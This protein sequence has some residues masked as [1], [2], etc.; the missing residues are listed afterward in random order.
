MFYPKLTGVKNR[1]N[2]INGFSGLSHILS[3]DEHAFYDMENLTGENFPL[4]SVRN[5]RGYW[6]SKNEDSGEGIRYLPF[7]VSDV[8]AAENVSGK[9]CFSGEGYFMVNGRMLDKVFLVPDIKNRTIVPFGRN[10]YVA[11][12]GEYIKFD[13]EDY[14]VYH[15][16]KIFSAGPSPVYFCY[17]DGT[18]ITPDYVNSLPDN[19]SEG[20]KAVM[21]ED[22][23]MS[24]YIRNTSNWTLADTVYLKIILSDPSDSFTQ[25]ERV[26]VTPSA[27][28]KDSRYICIKVTEKE[29][30][31][32]GCLNKSGTLSSVFLETRA[33]LFDFAVEHNNRIWGCRFGLNNEGEF[34]NE[35]YASALGDPT[36]WY[37]FEGIST[38]S[39]QASVGAGGEFTG[40]AA[41]GGEVLFFKEEH[42]IRVT[43]N[44][45][46]DFQ[47][48]SFPARGVEKGASKSI[49]NLNERVFY[50][51]RSGIMVYDGAYPVLIS[52]NLG[53]GRFYDCVA[54]GH[55]GKYYIAMT[56][57]ENRRSIY[58]FDTKTGLWHKEDDKGNT[59]F[60]IP[61]E[62]SLF[63][64]C[65][66]GTGDGYFFL[67]H[68]I[69]LAGEAVNIF[70]D[71]EDNGKYEYIPEDE[72][73]W[74][75]ES[76]KLGGISGSLRQILRGISVTLSL[77]EGASV[78]IFIKPDN[79]D[80][81]KKIC[82]I[83]KH[84]DGVFTVPAATE[85][86]Y[87][88]RLRFEGKG[89]AVIH[90]ISFRSQLTNGVNG[91]G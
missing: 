40:V 10:I 49:A 33:P 46:S 16:N 15:G 18:V 62:G 23:Y 55:C 86:C 52:E 28:F 47:V 53:N 36:K 41:V 89:K 90:S 11:P 74:F 9:V 83:D 29:L 13:G 51:S 12:D 76:G 87:S 30:I 84:I 79:E 22:G 75:A 85:P 2:E 39:Y 6:C 67:I 38:D 69:S 91:I 73:S 43:G 57:E 64:L 14:K 1:I 82:F 42:I 59:R 20:Q 61:L 68:D 50:K 65:N 71:A 4:V 54:K 58:V 19:A 70:S 88:Y 45:P 63:Y 35:I 3:V 66:N 37:C 25:G 24:L 32:Q 81:W 31:L 27:Y 80:E 72:I 44:S 17:S 21:H 34:V 56:D 5:K 78:S 77:E 26:F 8:I 7:D 60:M 48:T